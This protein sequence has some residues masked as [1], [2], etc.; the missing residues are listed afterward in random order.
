MWHETNFEKSMKARV[1]SDFSQPEA[2]K[3]CADY[4]HA[5]SYLCSHIYSNIKATEP[6]L[7]D[8][9]EDHIANVLN[10]ASDLLG[11]DIE[12]LTGIELYALGISILFHD[13][14]NLHGR[15][16]HNR[17]IH[18][19]F[20]TSR[21]EN[22][23][24]TQEFKVVNA[25]AGAH[26]GKTADGS[27]TDTISE[28]AEM[29]VLQKK[30]I[31]AQRL[32]AVL[33]LADELAEGS[34]RTSDYLLENKMYDN[35]SKVFHAYAQGTD[36]AIMRERGLISLI[37]NIH[38]TKNNNELFVADD[39]PLKDYLSTIY[40]RISKLDSERR[41][42]RYYCEWLDPFKQVNVDIDFLYNNT[43]LDN[44]LG[45]IH[46]TLT[47][48]SNPTSD[49]SIVTSINPNCEIDSL[50]GRVHFAVEALND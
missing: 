34:Q 25:I 18:K 22:L 30:D 14:G 23:E 29:L 24:F 43:P 8:H 31:R 44:D 33:R 40:N 49:P 28:V 19:I 21:A 3:I 7:T 11:T 26:C 46:V 32:A 6:N 37:Y 1:I 12:K 50:V 27:S 15:D 39:I 48:L 35:S 36:V 45:T 4:I 16:R 47:D 13:V 9:G 41:Y 10:N 42:C 20:T 17:K 5:K 38:L 2:E